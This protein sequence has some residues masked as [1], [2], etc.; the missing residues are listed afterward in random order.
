MV[1]IQNFGYEEARS[2]PEP[3][4][5][6]FRPILL[7]DVVEGRTGPVSRVLTLEQRVRSS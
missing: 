5:I 3:A 7:A 2:P 4:I 1:L 6:P